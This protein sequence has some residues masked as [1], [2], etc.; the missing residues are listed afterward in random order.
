M[1]D[2][3]W[4]QYGCRGGWPQKTRK[5]FESKGWMR[6]SDYPVQYLDKTD[7]ICK[8]KKWTPAYK[9]DGSHAYFDK[10]P[11]V[12]KEALQLG[13]V[14]NVIYATCRSFY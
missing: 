7:M 10:D 6:A 14:V 1:G 11:A 5:F 4:G 13:P 2:G 12:W 9:F 3:T 8:A